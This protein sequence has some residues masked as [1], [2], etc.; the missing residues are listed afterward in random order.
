MEDICSLVPIHTL[1]LSNSRPGQYSDGRPLESFR[2]WWHGFSYRC[3]LNVS[4]NCQLCHPWCGCIVAVFV[5]RR[6][7]TERKKSRMYGAVEVAK[8]EIF[9]S[10]R[11]P[12]TPLNNFFQCLP[13]SSQEAL[14]ISGPS[15]PQPTQRRI[16][17]TLFPSIVQNVL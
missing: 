11:N 6:A 15:R 7:S 10:L 16:L 9:F 17:D 14:I 8:G 13:I 4:A 2:F 12:G 1:K 5:S 3:C